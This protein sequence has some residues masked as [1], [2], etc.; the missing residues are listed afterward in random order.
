MSP[1]VLVVPPLQPGAGAG[2]PASW[3]SAPIQHQGGGYP[4]EMYVSYVG[5]FK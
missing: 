2:A 3:G 4:Q 1:F 5:V